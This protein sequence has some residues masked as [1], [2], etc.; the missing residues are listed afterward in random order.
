MVDLLHWLLMYIVDSDMYSEMIFVYHE[1]YCSWFYEVFYCLL[2]NWECFGLGKIQSLHLEQSVVRQGFACF[3]GELP[4]M[5]S[6]TCSWTFYWVY[7]CARSCWPWFLSWT[8]GS[9]LDT[10]GLHD[11]ALYLLT[12]KVDIW[13]H[14]VCL[15]ST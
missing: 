12:L 7:S 14:L 3:L 4:Q 9:L 11:R 13:T 1:I 6:P 5:L 10:L 8:S 2:L 15:H